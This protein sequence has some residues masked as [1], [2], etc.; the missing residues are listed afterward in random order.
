LATNE[1][2]D[3]VMVNQSCAGKVKEWQYWGVGSAIVR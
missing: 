1:R 2:T 3:S